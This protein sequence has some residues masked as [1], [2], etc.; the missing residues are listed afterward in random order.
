M[1]NDSALIASL[2]EHLAA[3]DA[4]FAVQLAAVIEARPQLPP[5]I[6]SIAQSSHSERCELLLRAAHV[7]HTDLPDLATAQVLT[8]LADDAALFAA[9]LRA[10]RDTPA[11]IASMPFQPGPLSRAA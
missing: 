6:F 3:T 9:V 7:F 1:K 10:L 5:W 4:H 11:D 8:R 2:S